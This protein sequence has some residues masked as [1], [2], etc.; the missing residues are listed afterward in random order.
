M[1]EVSGNRNPFKNKDQCFTQRGFISIDFAFSALLVFTLFT[2][3][4]SLSFTLAVVSIS[5]Y[6][7]YSSSRAYYSG[8]FDKDSQ[9][10]AGQAKFQSLLA[11]PALKGLFNNRTFIYSNSQFGRRDDYT[12][13]NDNDVFDGFTGTVVA[14]ILEIKS[15]LFGNSSQNENEYSF[16]IT[17][18]LGREPTVKECES[19]MEQRSQ[20]LVEQA[21]SEKVYTTAPVPKGV[22]P[23]LDNGC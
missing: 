5:Q 2:V 17:S 11:S 7:G 1:N 23:F 18:F 6:I 16:N 10:A 22:R 4:F 13:T 8:N 12:R 3:F 9:V 19:F 21:E 14:K 15:P 20:K